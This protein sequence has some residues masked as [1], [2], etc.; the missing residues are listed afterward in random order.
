MP[1]VE[2]VPVP[3]E[4]LSLPVPASP[5]LLPLPSRSS[6]E[7]DM[8]ALAAALDMVNISVCDTDLLKTILITAAVP[9][10]DKTQTSSL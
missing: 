8:A 9:V 1:P 7:F 6:R 3:K 2:L 4:P 10:A 5:V